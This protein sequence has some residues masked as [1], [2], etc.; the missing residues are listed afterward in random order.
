MYVSCIADNVFYI[1]Y[2]RH[3][4]YECQCIEGYRGPYC[5]ERIPVCELSSTVCNNRGTCI[6]DNSEAGYHCSYNPDDCHD[7]CQHGGSCVEGERVCPPHYGGV[8]C[9]ISRHMMS[10]YLLPTR[11]ENAFTMCLPTLLCLLLMLRSNKQVA[12]SLWGAW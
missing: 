1:F 10:C 5:E 2:T 4:H 3:G 7:L 12:S 11:R 6:A 9:E 8:Y